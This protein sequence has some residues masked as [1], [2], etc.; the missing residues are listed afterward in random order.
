MFL[1]F[2]FISC[3]CS[4]LLII[5]YYY[6]NMDNTKKRQQISLETKYE[7]CLMRKRGDT[8]GKIGQHFEI[9]SSSTVSTILGQSK[10]IIAE[11]EKNENEND[12]QRNKAAKRLRL[13]TYQD[14]DTAVQEWFTQ[15]TSQ[16]NV[17]IGGYEIQ[18]QA[19]KYANM[20]NKQEFQASNGWLQ[21][22]RARNHISFKTIVG[23]AGLVDKTVIDEY[24]NN[25][26]PKLIMNYKPCDIFNADQ[27]ALFYKAQPSKTMIYKHMDANIVKN[28]KERLT[29]LLTANMDGSEKLK[30]LVIDKF[31]NPRCF[32]TK[33]I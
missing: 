29:L 6:V 8:P 27:T 28:S 11:Y 18:R 22:F 20:L 2:L 21:R 32:Q 30:P 23:E 9:R 16:I 5:R 3:F 17:V 14:I 10:K 12:M 4:F 31:A 7:M 26:L 1:I 24:L 19:L 15:A 33:R 13:P 25:I